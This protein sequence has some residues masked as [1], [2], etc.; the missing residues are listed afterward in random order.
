MRK[1]EI[2]RLAR[3]KEYVSLDK[4]RSR[5]EVEFIFG[6]A[7]YRLK[8]LRNHLH[9]DLPLAELATDENYEQLFEEICLA[10]IRAGIAHDGDTFLCTTYPEGA[11]RIEPAGAA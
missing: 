10:A 9:M 1:T 5:Y 11:H 8:N 6:T 7:E 2:Q 4:T 3:R